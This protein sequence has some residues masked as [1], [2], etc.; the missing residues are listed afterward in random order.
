M[1]ENLFEKKKLAPME[2]G[3]SRAQ[4]RSHAQ[5]VGAEKLAPKK[6]ID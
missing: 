3:R 1:F 2:V 5:R 4:H 6:I